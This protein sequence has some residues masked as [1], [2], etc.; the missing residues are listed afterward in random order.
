[1]KKLNVLTKNYKEALKNADFKMITQKKAL[2]M[3]VEALES[4]K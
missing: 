2:Q 1:M 4:L 3:V